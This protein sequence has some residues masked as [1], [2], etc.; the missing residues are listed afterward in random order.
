[1]DVTHQESSASSSQVSDEAS[2]REDESQAQEAEN[3]QSKRTI[4]W[5]DH[6]RALEDMKKFKARSRELEE[7][8]NNTETKHLEEKKNYK[9]LY[10]REKRQR[11]EWQGK[12]T[13]LSNSVV[14]NE[15]YNAVRAEAIKAGIINEKDLDYLDLDAVQIERTD[16][17][18]AIV[19]GA[20][21]FVQGLIKE[22]PYWFKNNEVPGFNAGGGPPPRVPEQKVEVVDEAYISKLKSEDPKRFEREWREGDLKVR[23]QKYLNSKRRFR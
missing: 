18:R 15:K 10:E 16:H 3:Q 4:G 17:G 13:G 20:D 23:F 1:M 11:E 12:Y 7:Q 14:D 8:L 22:R 19:H 5:E 21:T 9:E 2:Q 6:Q